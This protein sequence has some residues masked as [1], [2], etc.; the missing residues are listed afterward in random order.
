MV[1]DF[2]NSGRPVLKG[3]K[4]TG[5][6]NIEEKIIKTQSTSIGEYCNID[7]LYRTVHSANQL[8]IY[9][10]VTKWCRTKSGERSQSRP[11]SARKNI[12]RNSNQTGS[13]VIGWY[14]ETTACFGKPNASEF[15]RFQFDAHLWAK[16]HISVQ[17]R[18]STIRSRNEIIVL[19]I[20]LKMTDGE[21]ARQCA[22]I[23][24][25]LETWRTQG[26]THR[27][28]QTKNWSS[29]KFWD[30]YGYWCSWYWSA[31]TFTEFSR[32][33]RMVFD[34]SWSR[35]I[36]ERNSSSQLWHRELQFLVAHEGRTTQ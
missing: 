22:K 19:H 11:E 35:K 18:N 23:T 27:L 36:C 10:A 31:S 9:A 30:C 12:P 14:S 13:Q 32:T 4:S 20:L 33:L 8:C 15:E 7:L 21:S 34:K 28:M 5:P 1:E 25:R 2:E 29:L 6:W 3:G 26:H 17:R 16:L 24:Q